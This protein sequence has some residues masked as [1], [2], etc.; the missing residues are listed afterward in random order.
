MNRFRFVHAADL[1]LDSPFTGLKASAPENVANCL[2]NATFDAYENIVDLCLSE[3]VDALLIAGD[4][5]DGRDRSLRAQ[6]RFVDGLER[7]HRA[8][9]RSFVCHGNHDP[10]DGWEA[11]LTYPSSC[12][13]FGAEFQA[14]PVFEDNPV[15]AVV[16]GVSYPKRNVT[17]NLVRRLGRVESA[18]FNIG[19]LHANVNN[20][21]RHRAYAPCS[22]D[23]L[24]RT[25]ID[26][27]ALGHV[28]TRQVLNP[29][30]PT[31]VYPGNPQG[32]HPTES[33]PRGVYL[34]EVGASG[35]ARMNFKPVDTVRWERLRADI[36]RAKTEQD[37]LDHLHRL[38]ENTRKR[39]KGRS[40]VVRITL[41]GRGVLHR[42][43]CRPDFREG[44]LEEVNG[45]CAVQS[46]F[47]WCERIEDRTRPA[48]DRKERLRGSDFLADLLRLCDRSKTDPELLARLR[49]GLDD[50]YRHRVFGRYLRDSVPTDEELAALIDEAESMAVDLLVE[51]DDS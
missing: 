40:L 4:V 49:N 29:G 22:L 45:A 50:L 35:R 10:L 42:A 2:Y 37:L 15:H 19:L 23:D 12:H 8:G 5:Y 16:H 34:V 13:R 43:L 18:S 41:T 44:L 27:W 38:V 28:H 21:R 11:R 30:S 32:R 6:R 51:D 20:D 33:G 24:V 1:H 17:A 39:G 26:Y 7:L 47:V 46:P 31:V 9:I 36:S 25:G 48:F 14:V 3:R